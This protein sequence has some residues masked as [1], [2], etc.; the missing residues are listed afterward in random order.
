MNRY[1]LYKELRKHR[2]LAEKRSFLYQQNKLAKGLLYFV[3]AMVFAYLVGFAIIFAMIANESES[4]T[5]LELIFGLSPFI[6]T[7]DFLLRFTAQQTPSQLVHPYMLLPI[8]RYACVDQF[9]VTSLLSTGNLTWF[10]M[11]LPYALMAVV[12][13]YGVGATLLY[14]LFFWLA[15]MANSQWYLIVRTLI[16][17]KIAWWILPGM[18][19]ALMFSP[20]YLGKGADV[21]KLCDTYATIGSALESCSVLPILAVL[22]ALIVLVA[23]NRRI[24]H[25]YIIKELEKCENK[26]T[27]KPM[28]IEMLER[29]G[30]IGQFIQLEIKNTL[31]NKNPRKT[32]IFMMATV[33]VLSLIISFTDVYDNPVM[34]NF[35][36][37][38]NYVIGALPL[39][40]IMGYEGNYIDA[41]MVR[42]ENILTLLKAKYYFYAFL[43]FI[44]FLLMLPTVFYGKWT[45]LML[46]SYAVFTAGFQFFVLFQMAVYNKQTIP[47]NTKFI[48]K[49]SME[50]NYFQFAAEMVCFIVPVAFVTVLQCFMSVDVS[51]VVTLVVGILFILTRN[52]WMRN[53]YRRMMKKRYINMEAFRASR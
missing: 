36:C 32:F 4:T 24:Q 51:H 42:K 23:I 45:L 21:N 7:L 26:V 10:A 52:V 14:L 25:R 19:Y 13:S 6:L 28:R 41:L 37:I 48:G 35:W 17:S 3:A 49:G 16:N 8:S 53:V 46:V 5:A 47:L 44:P 34:A 15:I 20:W 27:V 1:Q 2:E 50:S 18:V 12:F 11:F 40:R 33:F 30:E 43:L 38:Y 39:I 31:R 9:V 29:F 22:A